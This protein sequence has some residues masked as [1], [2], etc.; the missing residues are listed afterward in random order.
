MMMMVRGSG[1]MNLAVFPN[2][3]DSQYAHDLLPRIPL[4]LMTDGDI[5]VPVNETANRLFVQ[6]KTDQIGSCFELSRLMMAMGIDPWSPIRGQ[7][8]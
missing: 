5:E 4:P 8:N 7:N 3:L 1:N 6:F 2:T